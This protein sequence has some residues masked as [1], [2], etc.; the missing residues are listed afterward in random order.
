[1]TYVLV[2][3][4][5]LNGVF[6]KTAAVGLP[7]SNVPGGTE[8]FSKGSSTL[9]QVPTVSSLQPTD[10]RGKFKRRDTVLHDNDVR[11]WDDALGVDIK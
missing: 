7:S 4:D 5:L 8:T 1:M 10:M 6:V 3:Q 9:G 2:V 11:A